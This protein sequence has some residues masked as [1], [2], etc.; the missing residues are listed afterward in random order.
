MLI[1]RHFSFTHTSAYYNRK[2]EIDLQTD[3]D[4]VKNGKGWEIRFIKKYLIHS[5]D[6]RRKNT[7]I[8]QFFHKL[9]FVLQ[10]EK[11]NKAAILFSEFVF[12]IMKLTLRFKKT[13][14]Q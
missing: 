12:K 8:L 9:K 13:Q 2:N 10:N 14:N 1:F 7:L 5:A 6:L 3:Y 11:S 4:W